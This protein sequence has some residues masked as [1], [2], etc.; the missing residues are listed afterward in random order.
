MTFME[1]MLTFYARR[2]CKINEAIEH[3]DFETLGK[4]TIG[5]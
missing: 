1:M 3:R 4:L 5:G 2:L